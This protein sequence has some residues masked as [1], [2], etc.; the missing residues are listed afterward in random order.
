MSWLAIVAL[1]AALV[2]AVVA[3]LDATV[4]RRAWPQLRAALWVAVLAAL[5]VPPGWVS[6]LGWDASTA[7]AADTGDAPR[8]DLAGAVPL[9]AW[10][11]TAA[12]GLLAAGLAARRRHALL[13]RDAHALPRRLARRVDDVA[14]RARLAHAPRIVV[15]PH[16]PSPCVV[17]VVRPVVLVPPG[18]VRALDTS[19]LDDV[20][21]HECVHV[22]RRD[23]L[24]AALVAL[25]TLVFWWHPCAWLAARRLATLREFC[26]DADVAR[27]TGD[28][29]RYRRTLAH[30]ALLDLAPAGVVGLL[31]AARRP[32]L[33][34]RLAALQRPER[35]VPT[36]TR[37]IVSG[38]AAGALV[39]ACLPGPSA[40]SSTPPA[41]S[42]DARPPGCFHLRHAV[43][44][45]QAERRGLAPPV[46]SQRLLDAVR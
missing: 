43:L 27:L 2:S 5:V 40:P 39:L 42:V 32:A 29:A 8:G 16:A 41:A 23:P 18:V 22:R 11:V 3:L 21:L 10:R 14:R 35:I 38:L 13:T 44:A 9:L 24:G 7:V 26:C 46:T 33:L 30:C 45:A 1:R 28:V 25:V 37:R 4:L 12:V 20:L 15:A 6:P 34:S 36:A 17:G 31:G 19:A